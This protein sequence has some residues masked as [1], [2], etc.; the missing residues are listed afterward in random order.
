[1]PVRIWRLFAILRSMRVSISFPRQW[2]GRL[3][4]LFSLL[5]LL[6]CGAVVGS[7]LHDNL[8]AADLT[9]VLGNKVRPDGQPSQAL[10]ARLDHTVRLYQQG[11]CK[12]ILVSGGHGKEGYDEPVVMRNYLEEAGVPSTIIFEDNGGSNTWHTAQNTAAFMKERHLSSVLVVSQY[13]HLP[14]CRLALYECGVASVYTSHA[15]YWSVRD[16]FSVPREV[17]GLAGYALRLPALSA[18]STSHA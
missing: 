4:G 8:H 2:P 12:L 15:P 10:K 17:V 13:F 14:R 1:M 11:Y 18:A 9:V 3:L 5:L 7:G 16:F 6:A